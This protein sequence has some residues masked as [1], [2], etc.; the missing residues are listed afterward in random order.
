[1]TAYYEHAGIV[2]YHG[3][4]LDVLSRLEP[5]TFDAIVTDPPYGIDYQSAW[6][7]DKAEWKP[8]I[9]N[10]KAPF[11]WWLYHGWRVVREGG[12]VLCFCRWDT[13]DVFKVAL[14][15]AGFTTRSQVI[16]DRI[17]H[18]MGDLKGAYAPQHDVIWFATKGAF[19]FHGA[20]P[21]SIVRAA[22]LSGEA[23]QHPNEKP[24]SLMVTL[25]RDVADAGDVVLDPMMG[26][27][28]TLVA[29]KAI[30]RRAVGIEADERY[31]ELAAK[32]LSQE[33][34]PLEVA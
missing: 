31:C 12:C 18:G 21:K 30:G 13:Q 8:K 5:E 22:R 23:L 29:A 15:A 26:S 20:R 24:V 7:T 17:D 2:I 1:M 9:R 34:L 14:D 10:D 25:V 3:D 33:A 11:I 16:W 6:R 19:D 28:T 4:C 32:R 27:G